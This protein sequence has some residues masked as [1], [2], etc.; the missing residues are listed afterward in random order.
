MLLDYV[1]QI[2]GNN[3]ALPGLGSL[4]IECI[5]YSRLLFKVINKL[6]YICIDLTWIFNFKI[7]VLYFKEMFKISEYWF[8]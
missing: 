7:L 3:L 6:C 4:L 1:S 8:E 2:F 5:E